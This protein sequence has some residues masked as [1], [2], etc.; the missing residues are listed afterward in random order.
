M[1]KKRHGAYSS[2]EFNSLVGSRIGRAYLCVRRAFR[3]GTAEIGLTPV[4]FTVLAHI[5]G[6]DAQQSGI[7]LALGISMQNL[8]T[9]LDKL[10]Q[11]EII[12]RTQSVKDRRVRAIRL[13][14]AGEDLM[15]R[16]AVLVDAV[17]DRITVAMTPGERAI[18]VELLDKVSGPEGAEAKTPDVALQSIISD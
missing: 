6:G 2:G 4:E 17:E 13:T 10:E 15:E 3:A 16:A 8:T 14:K 7:S 9:I 11:R 12:K 18:F 5:S 1:G